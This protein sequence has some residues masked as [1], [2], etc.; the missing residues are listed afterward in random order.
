[1]EPFV[2]CFECKNRL[3]VLKKTSRKSGNLINS[4][5]I[6]HLFLFSPFI[7]LWSSFYYSYSRQVHVPE[8]N[9]KILQSSVF[10][11]SKIQKPKLQKPETTR[12]QDVVLYITAH[13]ASQ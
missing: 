5:A 13:C 1:M 3:E 9:T 6:F 12:K 10:P 2:Q 4:P 8:Q 7:Y 11:P